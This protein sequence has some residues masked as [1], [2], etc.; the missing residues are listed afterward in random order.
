MVS[1]RFYARLMSLVGPLILPH[2]VAAAPLDDTFGPL[3]ADTF[4]RNGISNGKAAIFSKL[5]NGSPLTTAAVGNAQQHS[6]PALTNA[7]ASVYF[8]QAG[9]YLGDAGQRSNKDMLW[10]FNDHINIG[11]TAAAFADYQIHFIYDVGPGLDGGSAPV[12]SI[13]A[14]NEILSM[15]AMQYGSKNPMPHS[16]AKDYP[17]IVTVSGGT[18]EST[19]VTEYHSGIQA[20]QDDWG[21]EN[22]AT[23]RQ[24]EPLTAAAWLF[25]SALLGLFGIAR[26]KNA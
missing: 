17:D 12:G 13:N 15:P 21:M 24:V 18:F 11:S 4:G 8:P 19:A 14:T 20:A 2:C 23:D 5:S 7:G 16:L 3:D 9:R 10:D 6:T 1:I 25:G 26:R 22:I